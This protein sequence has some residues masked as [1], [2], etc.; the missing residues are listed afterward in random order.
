MNE[1]LIKHTSKISLVEI[2][3][4]TYRYEKEKAELQKILKWFVSNE[5]LKWQKTFQTEFYKEIFRLCNIPFTA[6][7]IRKKPR[8]VC[9]ATNELI[10]KNM[11]E[12]SFVSDELKEKTLK[13]NGNDYNHKLHQSLTPLGKENLKKVIYS[14][15]TL[16]SISKN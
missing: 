10:Y 4:P 12:N 11:P 15:E 7:N 1:K 9:W 16:A 3:K 14:V 6:E 2:D 13:K 5:T 8:F